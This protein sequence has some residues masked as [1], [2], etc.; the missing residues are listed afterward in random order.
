MEQFPLVVWSGLDTLS[1]TRGGLWGTVG[2]IQAASAGAGSGPVSP[3]QTCAVTKPCLTSV[4][5][6]WSRGA[7][8]TG[9]RLWLR[10]SLHFPCVALWHVSPCL[11]PLFWSVLEEEGAVPRGVP[12]SGPCGLW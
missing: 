7:L 5:S 12:V 9:S 6:S 2:A 8:G 3:Q 10:L 11:C 1:D 4:P